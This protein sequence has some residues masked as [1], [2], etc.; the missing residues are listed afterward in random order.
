MKEKEKE[1]FKPCAMRCTPEQW[2]KQLKPILEL[3]EGVRIVDIEDFNEYHYIVNNYIQ[4]INLFS[5]A[6]NRTKTSN[7]RTVLE[8]FNLCKFLKLS[9]INVV[10]QGNAVNADKIKQWWQNRLEF[11]E[12]MDFNRIDIFYGIVNGKF[13]C[14]YKHELPECTHIINPFEDNGEV[15]ETPAK[16]FPRY[17]YGS[18]QPM[19]TNN[20]GLLRYAVGVIGD[21]IWFVHDE[22]SYNQVQGGI[23][24][25]GVFAFK[26]TREVDEPLPKPKYTIDQLI[27]MAGLNKDEIEV[28]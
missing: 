6:N 26:Y 21:K 7:N 17:M 16:P 22:D 28:I 4:E 15:E 3:I 2:E 10:I 14:W 8:T 13:Y 19:D 20:E 24:G 25:I 11:E 1:N 5:N 23:S 27:E 12:L 18:G 9:G